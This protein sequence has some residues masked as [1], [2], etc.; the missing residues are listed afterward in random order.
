MAVKQRLVGEAK[1]IPFY[2]IMLALGRP[3]S[4]LCIEM[5]IEMS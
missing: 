5:H 1:E 2:S 4:K 3:Y